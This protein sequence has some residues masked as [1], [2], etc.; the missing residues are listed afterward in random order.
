MIQDHVS[1][2]RYRK[3]FEDNDG[4]NWK[5]Q[6]GEIQGGGGGGGGGVGRE[7]ERQRQRDRETERQR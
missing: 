4:L 3:T 2:R 6:S 5:G 7:R 1:N